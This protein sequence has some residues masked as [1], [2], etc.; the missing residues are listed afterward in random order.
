MPTKLNRI[1]IN[2]TDEQVA[3]LPPAPSLTARVM[4]ALGFEPPIWGG[5]RVKEQVSQKPARKRKVT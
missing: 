5:S 4:L 2:L 1:T 3:Q